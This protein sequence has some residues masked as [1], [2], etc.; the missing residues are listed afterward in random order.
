MLFKDVDVVSLGVD[1]E[2]GRLFWISS[3]KNETSK[4][5]R[6]ETSPMDGSN[7]VVLVDNLP[8]TAH[9]LS[10]DMQLKNLYWIEDYTIHYVDYEGSKVTTLPLLPKISVT[11]ATV[12]KEKIYY[13]DDNEQSIRSANKLTGEEDLLLRNGTGN[14]LSLRIYDPSEQK[15]THICAEKKAGCDHLCLPNLADKFSCKCSTGYRVDP[16]NPHKCLGTEE[17]LFYSRGYEINGLALDGSNDSEVLGYINRVSMASAVDFVVDKDLIVWADGDHGVITTI[18]RDGSDRRTVIEP[19]EGMEAVNADWL[20][21]LAVDWNA[22][23]VYW[24]D[25]KRG[26]I[27]VAR[28]NGSAQHILLSYEIGKPSC[29]A[30]DAA[31]GV[32]VWAGGARIEIAGLDGSNRKVLVNDSLQIEDLALDYEN[33]LVYWCDS[34]AVRIERIG[35]DG[36]NREIVLNDVLERPISLTLLGDSLFWIDM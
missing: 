26:V 4:I 35:Y 31:K 9:C 25:P 1:P 7:R 6:V 24:S 13:A 20:A 34:K 3:H 33:G 19:L 17:F 2:E 30:L 5:R 18:H 36:N 23:N 14:V 10:I 8:V 16:E 29:L 11:A 15:G 22:E 28:L 12:Y 21:G 27:H 32:L